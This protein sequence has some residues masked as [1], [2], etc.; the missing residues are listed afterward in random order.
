MA[1]A[2]GGRTVV[3]C[4]CLAVG[5]RAVVLGVGCPWRSMKAA[6]TISPHLVVE[7]DQEGLDAR[8][9]RLQRPDVPLARV[10]HDQRVERRLSLNEKES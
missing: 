3:L 1:V 9:G 5:G 4:L 2:V 6:I 10:R 7:P 8:H